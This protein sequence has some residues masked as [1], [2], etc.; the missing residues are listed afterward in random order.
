MLV[1]RSK[2]IISSPMEFEPGE[3]AKKS[4]QMAR[5]RSKDTGPEMAVRRALHARG[6]R[7]R[8]H[9]KNLP[10]RPDIVLPSR[11][12]LVF[13]HGCFWHGCGRCDRGLRQPKTRATFWAS[14]ISAN[15][16]RDMR[17]AATLEAMGW[18]ILTI[19]ECDIRNPGRLEAILDEMLPHV[20]VCT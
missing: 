19:W 10:G 2:D 17:N 7:F 4:L 18:R 11:Q 15:R 6:Y 8:L 5:V 12:T 14:K 20:R 9:R 16:E 3:R 13:V 1:E